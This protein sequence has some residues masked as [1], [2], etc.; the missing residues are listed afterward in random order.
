MITIRCLKKDKHVIIDNSYTTIYFSTNQNEQT[1][2][3]VRNKKV[4]NSDKKR[5][6]GYLTSPQ[7]RICMENI[8]CIFLLNLCHSQNMYNRRISFEVLY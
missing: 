3:L 7:E 6:Q 8:N 5:P 2:T 1:L 4:L